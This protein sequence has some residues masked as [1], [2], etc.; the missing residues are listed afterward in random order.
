[1]GKTTDREPFIW[2]ESST[3]RK[4]NLQGNDGATQYSESRVINSTIRQNHGSKANTQHRRND[5]TETE[6]GKVFKLLWVQ[7]AIHTTANSSVHLFISKVEDKNVQERTSIE[8][9]R[10][11]ISASRMKTRKQQKELFPQSKCVRKP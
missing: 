7:A 6:T 10:H 4:E 5:D 2:R 8:T 1:L 9:K 11:V 3:V